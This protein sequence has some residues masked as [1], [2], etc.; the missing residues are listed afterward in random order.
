MREGAPFQ[1]NTEPFELSKTNEEPMELTPDYLMSSADI[2][3]PRFRKP[4]NK[5]SKKP[6][7]KEAALPVEDDREAPPPA[8]DSPN[9][10]VPPPSLSD[11]W[12]DELLP[13]TKEKPRE[14]TSKPESKPVDKPV[15]QSAQKMLSPE[16]LQ[17]EVDAL[18]ADVE[19]GKQEKTGNTVAEQKMLSQKLQEQIDALTADVEEERRKKAA[20]EA[21]DKKWYVRLG[22][23]LKN[24]N[25][26]SR[27]EK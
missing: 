6:V 3:V 15:E 26:F 1:R 9:Y 13:E 21:H 27:K 23:L 5:E 20:Q 4:E 12:A 22:K 18:A 8:L 10:T 7:F 14:K 24:F 11:N 2:D 25:P 16:E 19:K 17:K